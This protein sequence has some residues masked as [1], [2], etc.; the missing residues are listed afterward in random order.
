[1]DELARKDDWEFERARKVLRD[2][3][4]GLSGIVTLI[5][6]AL[7][8]ARLDAL[9]EAA[10]IAETPIEQKCCGNGV[11]SGY[12]PPECCCNPEYKWGDPG[13]I[14]AAIRDLKD[15]QP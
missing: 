12:G 6:A 2:T 1:M 11:W 8:Q 7:L 4:P 5:A 15:K 9:E 3:G 10:K 13:E 14:A